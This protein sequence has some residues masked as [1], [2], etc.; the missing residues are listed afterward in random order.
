MSL[1]SISLNQIRPPRVERLDRIFVLV[2]EVPY[3][4]VSYGKNSSRKGE[5]ERETRSMI[6]L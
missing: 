4:T 5:H 2:E 1:A 6:I 3:S